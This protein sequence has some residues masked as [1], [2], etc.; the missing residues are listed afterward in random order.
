MLHLG[1]GDRVQDLESGVRIVQPVVAV[2]RL[3]LQVQ[4]ELGVVELL[5]TVVKL[6]GL[7]QGD[8]LAVE[9]S[10][11]RGITVED[12]VTDLNRIVINE[13]EIRNNQPALP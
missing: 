10:G 7:D 5:Q 8:D 1:A 12:L 3:E 2:G 9:G 13:L 6:A 4:L 11:V